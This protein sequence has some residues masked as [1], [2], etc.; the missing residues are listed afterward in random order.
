MK[1]GDVCRNDVCSKSLSCYLK[2]LK[3]Q[4]KHLGTDHVEMGR[5]LLKVGGIRKLTESFDLALMTLYELICIFNYNSSTLVEDLAS[6]FCQLAT[7][8]KKQGECKDAFHYY[9]Q[10]FK[11]YKS[12]ESDENHDHM[13]TSLGE[14]LKRCKA[15]AG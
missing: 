12:E 5:T 3:A 4:K 6:A 9:W 10:E 8:L 1:I 11:L 7:I 13:L 2:V 15:H 14:V